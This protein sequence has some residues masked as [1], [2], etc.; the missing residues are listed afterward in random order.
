MPQWEYIQ[1]YSCL[2]SCLLSVIRFTR[3]E[4]KQYFC[5]QLI[6]WLERISVEKRFR[7][8][9]LQR[10]IRSQKYKTCCA[11]EW[12]DLI[13]YFEIARCMNCIQFTHLSH[14]FDITSSKRSFIM[15][16]TLLRYLA[17]ELIDIERHMIT[18][19][20]YQQWFLEHNF[21]ANVYSLAHSSVNE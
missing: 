20:N 4:P 15:M 11:F 2:I 14:I 6:H 3:K 21:H 13:E 7:C 12:S 5:N 8:D 9:S 10:Y 17:F 16:H 19:S 1:S 18:L